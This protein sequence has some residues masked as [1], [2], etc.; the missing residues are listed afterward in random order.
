VDRPEL[1][2]EVALGDCKA[3]EG[4]VPAGGLE[5]PLVEAVGDL[6]RERLERNLQPLG[7]DLAQA[8]EEVG[9]DAVEVNSEYEPVGCDGDPL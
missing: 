5:V 3:V 6:R 7:G 8:P 9:A 2:E 1:G 4:G